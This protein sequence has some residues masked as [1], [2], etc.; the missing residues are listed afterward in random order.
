[1]RVASAPA[2]RRRANRVGPGERLRNAAST[3]RMTPIR[4]FLRLLSISFERHQPRLVASV[5]L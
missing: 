5:A 3:V 2:S 4:I 1:L